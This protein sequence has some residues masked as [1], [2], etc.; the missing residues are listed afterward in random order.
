[1]GLFYIF[2]V[3][4]E[5]GDEH[6]S[7]HSEH[8]RLR[9][10]GPPLVFWGYFAAVTMMLIFMSL[11]VKDPLLK[12]LRGEDLLNRWIGILG[13]FVLLGIPIGGLFF[14]FYEKNIYK[15]GTTLKVVHK[16]FFIPIYSKVYH[17][18]NEKDVFSVKHFMDTPNYAR[19]YGEE[20]LKSYFNRG[21]YQLWMTSLDGKKILLDRHSLK[22]EL[23]HL[24]KLLDRF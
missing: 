8:L 3:R 20:R 10:Y 22:T 6:F 5:E 11:A 12:M 13:I 17:L 2:P 15:Q 9:T 24:Q 1:M 18:K 4:E 16:V 19:M 14:F 7:V 23:N 21:Y